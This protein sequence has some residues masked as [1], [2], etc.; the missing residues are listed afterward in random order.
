MPSF[1]NAGRSVT[2]LASPV[3][4]IDD[5]SPG[6]PVLGADAPFWHRKALAEMSAAEWES[7]CDGCGK[8]CLEK[9]EDPD[10]GEIAHTNVACPLFD[11][12]RCRCKRYA[13]RQRWVAN[14]ERLTP[15]NVGRLA[16][17]P[18][19]CAY[20]RLA[21][22]LDLPWWHHLVSGDPELVHRVKQSARGRVVPA[23][24]AGP[25]E[26]HIVAWPGE[27]MEPP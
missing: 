4:P 27:N 20:R 11:P 17:L 18:P 19:T 24:R 5:P 8:C 13:D 3:P 1:P 10:T 9:L 23:D 16:W 15:E 7:L 6:D 12:R 22:G 14:C 2:D 25:L 21:H 26:R